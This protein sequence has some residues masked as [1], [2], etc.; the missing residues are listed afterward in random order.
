MNRLLLHTLTL[1]LG[2]SLTVMAGATIAPSLPAVAAHFAEMEGAADWARRVMTVPGVFI[3][4]GAPLAGIVIDR[5][6][7]KPVFFCGVLLYAA[8]GT[9]GLWVDSMTG[10]LIGRAGLGMAVGLIMPSCTTLVGTLFK[11]PD[12]ARMLGTQA[13]F[14]G[15][16]GVVFLTMGGL[17]A[18]LGWRGPFAAYFASLILLPG[19]L[20]LPGHIARQ[21]R[22]GAAEAFPWGKLIG[23][24]LAGLTG[25]MAF[26]VVPTQLPF[27]LEER[28]ISA[29]WLVGASIGAVNLV[30]AV[31]SLNYRR[32]R[33]GHSGLM[34]LGAGFTLI[35][36]GLLIAA[37]VGPYA[38]TLGGL[39][40]VGLGMGVMMPTL[41]LMVLAIAPEEMR[42]RATGLLT[43]FIFI[44][45]FLSPDLVALLSGGGPTVS[46]FFITGAAVL[47]LG[48]VLIILAIGAAR[49]GTAGGG[50]EE[51]LHEAP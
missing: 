35:G 20:M 46:R 26:Y 23:V 30:S 8:A 11:G 17:L 29:P 3:V 10:L 48:P 4:L 49:K 13:A 24:Y 16:G 39:G 43:T 22:T 18:E 15:F 2:S 1:L 6:G 25:M 31:I 37:L 47:V 27:L 42:G 5:I 9:T 12:R 41:A 32:L 38:A 19:V 21:E 51:S 7:P 36:T 44:G 28:G 50:K 14:M 45:Q 33:G 34:L 40:V